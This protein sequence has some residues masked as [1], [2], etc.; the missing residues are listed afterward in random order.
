[1][2]STDVH[3]CCV[4]VASTTLAEQ[5]T[6]DV[7]A[8]GRRFDG[9]GAISGGGATSRLLFTC[10]PLQHHSQTC[11][12]IDGGDCEHNRPS[13]ARRA[14][15][16]AVERLSLPTQNNDVVVVNITALCGAPRFVLERSTVRNTQ[17]EH[18]RSQAHT[19]CGTFKRSAPN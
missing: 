3:R 14:H 15:H 9:Y 18:L 11:I 12:L 16:C 17:F 10:V 4:M 13:I 7:S 8:V 5:Y 19:N 2:R 6:I 1:M